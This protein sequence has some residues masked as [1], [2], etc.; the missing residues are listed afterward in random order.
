MSRFYLSAPLL[1]AVLLWPTHVTAQQDQGTVAGRVTDV[2]GAV[3]PGVTV[4]ASA[5]ET[6]VS[7][8]TVTN[9]EGLYTVAALLIGRYRITAEMPGFK[10]HVSDIVEV[11]AQS[12]VRVDFALELERTRGMDSENSI[13]QACVLRFRPILMTTMAALLGGVPL[14]LGQGSGSE[15]RQPLGYAMVGGLALSQML[16]LFT[17]PVIYLYLDRLQERLGAGFRRSTKKTREAEYLEAAE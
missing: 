15:L 17:T 3:L 7:V 10:R 6:G 9:S 16:T 12:R 11:H 14:M 13:Y 1:L 2:T 4:K 5:V 8:Q